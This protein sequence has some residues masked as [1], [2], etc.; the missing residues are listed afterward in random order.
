MNWLHAAWAAGIPAALLL[1]GAALAQAAPPGNGDRGQTLYESRCVACHSVDAHRVGPLHRGVV[2]RRAGGAPGY[3]YSEALARSRQVW[4]AQAL[5]AW[6]SNPEAL[7]PGQRMGYQ[8]EN[9][10]D[11]ADIVAY[12]ARLK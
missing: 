4:T 1:P 2:G 9:A 3:D 6:L 10:Q 5:N 12:L 7:I 11:R 8:V